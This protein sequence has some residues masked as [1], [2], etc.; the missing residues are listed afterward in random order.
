MKATQLLKKERERIQ[1]EYQVKCAADSARLA[2]RIRLFAPVL[3]ACQELA[4]V[5]VVVHFKQVQPLASVLWTDAVC[6]RCNIEGHIL[7]MEP[8][9]VPEAE[10]IRISQGN[11]NSLYRSVP[12]AI[13]W[14]VRWVAEREPIKEPS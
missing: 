5:E 4:E 2:A 7:H 9:N 10:N 6:L 3:A 13:S 14:L 8:S 11:A 1:S 12:E